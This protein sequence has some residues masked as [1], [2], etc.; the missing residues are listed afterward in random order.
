MGQT[1]GHRTCA[2]TPCGTEKKP[3]RNPVAAFFGDFT[4][5]KS[6]RSMSPPVTSDEELGRRPSSDENFYDI[7]S[8]LEFK[9]DDD[10]G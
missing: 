6:R 7:M 4:P 3:R 8:S 10:D 1:R 9:E 5:F 2:R